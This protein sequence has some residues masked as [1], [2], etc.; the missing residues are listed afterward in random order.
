[1]AYPLRLGLFL[2]FAGVGVMPLTAQTHP[3]PLASTEASQI[4]TS[5]GSQ[6]ALTIEHLMDFNYP[7]ELSIVAA[8]KGDR[9]AWAENK[10]GVRNIMVADAPQWIPRQVTHYQKDDG[11]ELT[12]LA[13]SSDGNLIIYTRGGAKNRDGEVPD[14]DGDPAGAEQ[15]VW[16]V[17]LSRGAP[18][19][20]DNGSA[21]KIAPNSSAITGSIGYLKEGKIWI[22]PLGT[23][24]PFEVFA[25]GQN[26]D[27][28][29]SPNG[30]QIAFVS[31]RSG[32]SLIPIYDVATRQIHYVTP[33][34]DRDTYPRWS[35]D[36][37]YIAFV[38]TPVRFGEPG[39]NLTA[40]DRPNPWAIWLCE[41][42]DGNTR[43]LWHSGNEP[44]DSLP[45]LP[46]NTIVSWGAGD[47]VVFSSEQDGW[48]HLYS[49]PASNGSPQL[50]TPGNF[51]YDYMSYSPDRKTILF[52]S[53]CE[54][55]DRRHLW[56]VALAGGP[57]Q[58]VTWEKASNGG[59]SSPERASGSRFWVQMRSI[60]RRPSFAPGHPRSRAKERHRPSRGFP[61][62]SGWPVG[63]AEAGDLQSGG[64]ARN[65]RAAFSARECRFRRK[66]SSH[67]THARRTATPAAPRLAPDALLLQCLRCPPIHG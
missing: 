13:F 55:I 15:A 65:S 29:W 47:T 8:P 10:H 50:L 14:P 41:T 51:E 2:A 33:S 4:A 66:A 9:I 40:P 21:P 60:P 38:R 25:H 52:S 30:K 39:S 64:R 42:A 6:N 3:R 17:L 32:H 67:R 58:Q 34:V 53:N 12:N 24:R 59:P 62:T 23:G 1:M 54:D 56:Q 36:G 63:D 35:P 27:V 61:R 37:R 31:T 16:K 57:P 22:A 44:N 11:Q 49:I 43:E 20:V 7:E 26:T 45:N 5:S 46:G 19:K 18:Q 48:Q 28:E